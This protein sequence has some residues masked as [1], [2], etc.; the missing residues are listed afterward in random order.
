MSRSSRPMRGRRP[1]R[2]MDTAGIA[3]MAADGRAWVRLGK[4]FAP[5]EEGSHWSKVDG[6]LLLEVET[7]PEGEDLTCRLA[8]SAGS[9]AGNG[10]WSIP[11]VGTVVVVVIPSGIVEF[12]PIVVA[13]LDC[14]AI[15]DD[16]SETRRLLVDD[17]EIAVRAPKIRM[18]DVDADQ[19]FIKGTARRAHETAFTSE[20]AI[21]IAAI[22]SIADP[23]GIATAK[24]ATA[25]AT[26][27]T[28]AASD[29]ST[30]FFGK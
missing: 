1:S 21:Y 20:L 29:L 17:R 25:I 19:A 27:E 9:G 5:G 11:R 7:M 18:G 2:K 14:N 3:A 28:A 15:P 4:V 16:V 23:P 6:I 10:D 30:I 8:S 12:E 24:M 22:K 13:V 26:Y